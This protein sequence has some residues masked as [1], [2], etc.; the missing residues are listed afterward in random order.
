MRNFGDSKQS[1]SKQK[2]AKPK[3]DWQMRMNLLSDR[4][5][6]LI[7]FVSCHNQKDAH[8][9]QAITKKHITKTPTAMH[10]I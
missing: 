5:R 1:E 8:L 10:I 4:L 7:K 2:W 6:S 3:F 9:K